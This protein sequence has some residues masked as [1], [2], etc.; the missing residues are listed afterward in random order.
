RLFWEDTT[1]TVIANRRSLLRKF[2]EL[3]L[4]QTLSPQE[5]LENHF[6]IFLAALPRLDVGNSP[7]CADQNQQGDAPD[8]QTPRQLDGRQVRGSQ[9]SPLL[10]GASCLIRRIERKGQERQAPVEL[11]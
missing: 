8:P 5:S 11:R 3:I 9:E 6:Q 2:A 4:R 7:V 10:S 1:I